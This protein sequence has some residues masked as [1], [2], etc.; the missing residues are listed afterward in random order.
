MTGL[1]SPHE[2]ADRLPSYP[3]TRLSLLVEVRTQQQVLE[4]DP[5][6]R[7]PLSITGLLKPEFQDL[8]TDRIHASLL[9]FE[10]LLRRIEKGIAIRFDNAS[11]ELGW[12]EE[13]LE[14]GPKQF[15]RIVNKITFHNAVGVTQLL[16]TQSKLPQEIRF[17]LWSPAPKE[18]I[19]KRSRRAPDSRPSTYGEK[20]ETQV[21]S[22]QPSNLLPQAVIEASQN[23]SV[24]LWLIKELG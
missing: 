12:V 22:Q 11:D 18:S 15:R 9:S 13:T 2:S 1:W 17:Y 6:T 3:L 7:I 14:L 5:V 24:S 16:T 23:P 10:M 21:G 4:D 8:P 20:P 19:F